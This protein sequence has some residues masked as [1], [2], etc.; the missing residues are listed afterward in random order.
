MPAMKADGPM[1]SRHRNV[2]HTKPWAAKAT[3]HPKSC[4]PPPI[5]TNARNFTPMNMAELNRTLRLLPFGPAPVPD[6]MNGESLRHLRRVAKR[7]VPGCPI[8]A[9]A[10]KPSGGIGDVESRHPSLHSGENGIKTPTHTD[11]SR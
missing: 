10:Q 1:L 11:L 4:P 5:L 7:A 3:R 2:G 6:R 9:Y 8:Y